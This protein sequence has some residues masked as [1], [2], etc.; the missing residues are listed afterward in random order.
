LKAANK[1]QDKSSKK[2]VGKKDK[3][4]SK[5][6]ATQKAGKKDPKKPAVKKSSVKKK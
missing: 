4:V 2:P 5:S 6:S 1:K 3:Q